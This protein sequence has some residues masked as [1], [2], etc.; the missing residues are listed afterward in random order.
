MLYNYQIQGLKNFFSN[1]FLHLNNLK[2]R[3][4]MN[5]KISMFVSCVKAVIYLLL[6]NLYDCSCKGIICS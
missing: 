3:T 1:T 5:A 2:D 4:A 6:H